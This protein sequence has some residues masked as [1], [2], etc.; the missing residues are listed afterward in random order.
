MAQPFLD[1]GDIGLVF[2][3]GGSG[4]GPQ[5]MWAH[6]LGGDADLRHVAHHD[7]GVH[8][9][10]REGVG[11]RAG[12]GRADTPKQRAIRFLAMA[13]GGQVLGQRSG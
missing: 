9:A 5:R 11:Q 12:I 6:V 2:Q 7:I 8:A 4:S 3:R 13:A 10:R 1:L